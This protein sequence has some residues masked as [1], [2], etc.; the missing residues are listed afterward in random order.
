MSF[1][2][3]DQQLGTTPI[4]ITDEKVKTKQL[5]ADGSLYA[6]YICGL[7]NHQLLGSTDPVYGVFTAVARGGTHMEVISEGVPS[8][9]QV[10]LN[11][12]TGRIVSAAA[13]TFYVTYPFYN[14]LFRFW[15]FGPIHME[16]DG[17]VSTGSDVIVDE[18]VL[19]Y[20]ERLVGIKISVDSDP[21][22]DV[23]VKICNNGT[24]VQTLSTMLSTGVSKAFAA[25]TFLKFAADDVLSVVINA[26]GSL[27][28]SNPKIELMRG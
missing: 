27:V 2:Q 5:A 25:L 28:V 6:G 20:P 9:G 1:I 10:L 19:P 7:T 24:P 16:G 12:A 4:D 17:L 23:A 26:S 21:L 18:V 13:N 22:G 14:R 8:S 3:F 11:Q 15:E